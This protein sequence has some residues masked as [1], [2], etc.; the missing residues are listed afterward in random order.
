MDP[1]TH[2]AS[3]QV[4]NKILD[5]LYHEVTDKHTWDFRFEVEVTPLSTVPPVAFGLVA[6]LTIV[7]GLREFMRSRDKFELKTAF[8]VHNFLLTLGS[9]TLLLLLSELVF[10]MLWNHGIFYA[11]CDSAAY[12]DGRLQF[13]YY[14]N[15]LSKYW[16]LADTVFLVLQKKELK[17]LH[18]YHHSLTM[19]LCVTQLRGYAAVQWVPILLNVFVHVVMYYYYFLT[20]SGTKPKDI[21]WRQW[22]TTTQIIQF[23]LDLIA[24][25]FAL[26]TKYSE[27]SDWPT[28]GKCHGDINAGWWGCFLL[29]SYLYLFID[30]FYNN[31]IK[32]SKDPKNSKNAK[33]DKID[34]L[35]AA[36]TTEIP[37]EENKKLS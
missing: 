29:S 1:T 34:V 13:V 31:Y 12:E 20:A 8:I 17:F 24:C 9:L 16:E 25:Y 27:N 14:L 37:K 5:S 3:W 28:Y 36:G 32:G 18:V 11:I 35:A 10:P 19:V 7:F 26:Y 15:Y 22:V 4:T 2:F 23:V 33:T 6:Y 30:F 21:W